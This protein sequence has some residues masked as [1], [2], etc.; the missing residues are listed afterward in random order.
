MKYL[1]LLVL[2]L[3]LLSCSNPQHE[4]LITNV[5]VIDV[6]SGEILTNRTVAIDGD[7][8]TVKINVH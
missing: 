3:A 6:V 2:L 7:S 1:S 8:I 4:L 5:D